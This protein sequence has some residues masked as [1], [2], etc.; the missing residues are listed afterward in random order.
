ML[1][2]VIPQDKSTLAKQMQ[3]LKYLIQ[4]DANPK[5]KLIHQNALKEL[6]AKLK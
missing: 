6:E 5:D 3:A 4:T 2:V 1:K